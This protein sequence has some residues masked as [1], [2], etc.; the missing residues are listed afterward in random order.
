MKATN[1]MRVHEGDERDEG[2]EGHEG[3]EGHEGPKGDEGI[4]IYTLYNNVMR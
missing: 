2:H 1:A 4:S 3:D